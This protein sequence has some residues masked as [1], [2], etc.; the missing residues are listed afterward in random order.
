MIR[1]CKEA[2]L[3]EPEFKQ[4]DVFKTIIWRSG[5]ATGQV[6]GEAGGEVTGEV[7]EEIRRVVIVLQGEMKRAEI[8]ETLQLRHDDY[9]RTN[10]IIPALDSGCIEMKYPEIPNHPNQ[11]YRLTTKG[12]ALAI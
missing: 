6:T 10:Y 3:N 9:F 8:Q 2:G 7:T 4:E 5:Q 12:K 11:R 1:L